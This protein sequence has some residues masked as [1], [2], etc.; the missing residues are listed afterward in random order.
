M[1]HGHASPHDITLKIST[2]SP[3]SSPTQGFS[4]TREVFYVNELCSH[5]DV[6]GKATAAADLSAQLSDFKMIWDAAMFGP[7]L[8]EQTSAAYFPHMAPFTFQVGPIHEDYEVCSIL[9]YIWI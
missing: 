9:I 3:L 1:Q 7:T 4:V 6:Y 8:E 2:P 5:T